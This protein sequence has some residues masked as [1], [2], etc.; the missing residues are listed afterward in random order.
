MRR[1]L[2]DQVFFWTA[3]DLERK[4]SDYQC[5]YNQSRTHS[6]INGATPAEEN[7]RQVIDIND[8]RWQRHCRGLMELPIA[9]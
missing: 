1:E 3:A 7:E 6:S 4:L 2:L 8:Y 5:Y 9:A